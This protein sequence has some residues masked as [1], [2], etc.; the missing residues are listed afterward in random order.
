MENITF[1]K[2]IIYFWE[3]NAK[4]TLGL[5]TH[6]H[7]CVCRSDACV[8]RHGP[9]YATRVLESYERQVC[10]IKAV[11]WNESHIV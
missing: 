2:Q 9:T 4:E 7:I 5:H 10:Y 1:Y 3:I 6:T 8:R 11:V